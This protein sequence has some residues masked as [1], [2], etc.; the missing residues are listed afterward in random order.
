MHATQ[1]LQER[2]QYES[3]G[4]PRHISSESALI[5]DENT[6]AS[7]NNQPLASW[8]NGTYATPNSALEESMNASVNIK[9]PDSIADATLMKEFTSQSHATGAQ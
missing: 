3:E 7:A 1:S 4:D 6:R 9:Q 5:P 8:T 2:D